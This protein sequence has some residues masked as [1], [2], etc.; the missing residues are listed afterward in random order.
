MSGILPYLIV[1]LG[2]PGLKYENTRHNI[3]F[4]VIDA[5]AR[6]W[7]VSTLSQKFHGQLGEINLE[8][9]KILLLKPQTYMNR[10]GLSVGETAAFYK[11]PL[12]SHLLVISDDLDLP[13]GALRLRLSGG[14]GGHNGIKSIIE[15]VGTEQ[16]P[17]LRLGIGR[18]QTNAESY[19]LA[20]LSKQERA[21]QDELVRHCIP[22]I[23]TILKAGLEKAMSQYNRRGP[24]R[25]PEGTK[26]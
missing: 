26:T 22:A 20:K 14:S 21:I 15:A 6:H 8:G 5:L 17:R 9:T 12:S 7:G 1:G 18:S 10:S 2:N 23:E 24:E 11:V 16:F 3:G 19:V 4:E 13:P 25:A